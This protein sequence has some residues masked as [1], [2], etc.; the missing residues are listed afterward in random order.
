MD[1][2]AWREESLWFCHTVQSNRLISASV[3]AEVNI[4]KKCRYICDTKADLFAS[5]SRPY[6]SNVNDIPLNHPHVRKVLSIQS[7]ELFALLFFVFLNLIQSFYAES[8]VILC[9]LCWRVKSLLTLQDLLAWTEH[10]LLYKLVYMQDICH[11]NSPWYDANRIDRSLM[12]GQIEFFILGRSWTYLVTTTARLEAHVR[13][14]Q[15][16]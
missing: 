5:I 11:L 9:W 4:K 13:N 8:T 10:P 6:P 16:L 1:C 7:F 14:I 3:W 15:L 2:C 12:A